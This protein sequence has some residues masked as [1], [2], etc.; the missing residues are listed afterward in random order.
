MSDPIYLGPRQHFGSLVSTEGGM[1]YADLTD[2]VKKKEKELGFSDE[3]IAERLRRMSGDTGVDLAPP[4]PP[5]WPQPPSIPLAPLAPPALPK[6][7]QAPWLP[8]PG[9]GG[10]TKAM[11]WPVKRVRELSGADP[12][13]EGGPKVKVRPVIEGG[14]KGKPTLGGLGVTFEWPF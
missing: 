8:I 1:V 14:E 11:E 13:F 4:Q 9:V 5:A 2:W 3:E 6:P 10:S 7:P 12:L